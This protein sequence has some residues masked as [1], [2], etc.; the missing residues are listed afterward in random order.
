MTTC[1]I[2]THCEHEAGNPHLDYCSSCCRYKCV[3]HFCGQSFR[4]HRLEQQLAKMDSALVK[5]LQRFLNNLPDTKRHESFLFRE[6]D[7]KLIGIAIIS[8]LGVRLH[9]DGKLMDVYYWDGDNIQF[10]TGQQER[11]DD[12]A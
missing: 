1:E 6:P 8:L 7:G 12:A 3:T 5:E 11:D 2:H 10:K 4:M 9:P